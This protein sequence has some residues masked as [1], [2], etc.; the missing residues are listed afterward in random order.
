MVH[1]PLFVFPP[2]KTPAGIIVGMLSRLSSVG[3][4]AHPRETTRVGAYEV[5]VVGHQS[6]RLQFGTDRHTKIRYLV[7]TGADI[8][9]VPP[10]LVH[11]RRRQILPPLQAVNGST[12]MT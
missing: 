11:R 6:S 2:P 4:P 7:D 10:T 8:Y 12:V 9:V 5:S 3:S 1:G